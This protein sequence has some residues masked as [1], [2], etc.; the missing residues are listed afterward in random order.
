MIN[1]LVFALNDFRE[2]WH[3]KWIIMDVWHLYV[4]NGNLQLC[5]SELIKLN[6]TNS[7]FAVNVM[8]T[9][10]V[11]VWT[12]IEDAVI[13]HVIIYLFDGR[14]N[15]F[16]RKVNCILDTWWWNTFDW[17]TG[18]ILQD[19]FFHYVPSFVKVYIFDGYVFPGT[20]NT[21]TIKEMEFSWSVQQLI[22]FDLKRLIKEKHT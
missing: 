17:V 14:Q 21:C 3:I 4:N 1:F 6:G 7:I 12:A 18:E 22:A 8:G 19:N 16:L 11:V 10:D 5:K 13:K 9:N 2:L 15:I 20:A